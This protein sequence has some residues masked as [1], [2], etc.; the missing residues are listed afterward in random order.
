MVNGP[1]RDL[2]QILQVHEAAHDD[3]IQAAYRRLS[4]LYHPDRN[5]SPDAGEVMAQLNHAYEV[6]S[7]PSKREDYD[8]SRTPQPQ[9]WANETRRAEESRWR[10]S[11]D[12]DPLTQRKRAF[13]E[14]LDQEDSNKFLMIMTERK[15]LRIMVTFDDVLTYD[16][17]K[18]VQ[19]RIGNKRIEE[20][21]W[22]TS[23]TGE[24][25]FVPENKTKRFVKEM[26]K[27]QELVLRVF[28]DYGGMETAVFQLNGLSEAWQEL[29]PTLEGR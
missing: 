24:A 19:Y 11:R 2:Y 29:M 23:T 1:E 25:V 20:E 9:Q 27:A 12:V 10:I 26:L 22:G 17:G 6:L 5:A 7:D 3:V 18:R 28:P 13:A 21:F 4:L 8:R 14:V 16:Y 15:K